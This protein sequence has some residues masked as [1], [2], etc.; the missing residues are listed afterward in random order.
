MKNEFLNQIASATGMDVEKVKEMEK[1]VVKLAH[2]APNMKYSEAKLFGFLAK[3]V[4]N[5]IVLEEKDETKS[6]DLLERYL[7]DEITG[8]EVEILIRGE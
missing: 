7:N 5:M 3:S 8:G 6:F 1:Q 4:I 2:D